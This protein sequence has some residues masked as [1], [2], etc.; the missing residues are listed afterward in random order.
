M[1]F[2]VLGLLGVVLAA[3]VVML[4]VLISRRGGYPFNLPGRS[5]HFSGNGGERNWWGTLKTWKSDEIYLEPGVSV[6]EFAHQGFGSYEVKFF[7]DSG[8]GGDSAE[9][10]S[11]I[12]RTIGAVVDSLAGTHFG[13]FARIGAWAGDKIGRR[14]ERDEW[15]VEGSGSEYAC[16]MFPVG[17]G[18]SEG[19]YRAGVWRLEVKAENEWGFR[20]VQPSIRGSVRPLGRAT[21]DFPQGQ[22]FAGPFRA[23]NSGLDGV[24]SHEGAGML[25]ILG[26]SLDGTHSIFLERSGQIY[27]ERVDLELIQDKQYMFLLFSAG[28]GGSLSFRK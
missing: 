21:L 22:S 15:V 27:E 2:W 8:I 18:R 3:L 28:G 16:F 26:C 24:L 13:S 23:D 1:D 12:G 4:W 19:W 9:S 5:W 17:S 25:S 11:D 20:M 10:A 7:L 6:L 14:L